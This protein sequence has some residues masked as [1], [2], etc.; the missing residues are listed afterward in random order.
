M[1]PVAFICLT[2]SHL[3]AGSG[4]VWLQPEQNVC[5]QIRRERTVRWR[6]RQKYGGAAGKH[7]NIRFMSQLLHHCRQWKRTFLKLNT[8]CCHVTHR[9]R[10]SGDWTCDLVVA[11]L[12]IYQLETQQQTNLNNIDFYLNTHFI[13]FLLLYLSISNQGRI[14]QG[15]SAAADPSWIS[16]NQLPA[17]NS[18]GKEWWYSF[19]VFSAKNIHITHFCWFPQFLFSRLESHIYH[20]CK[21][22]QGPPA[23]WPH[24]CVNTN[25]VCK[26]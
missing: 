25:N 16:D 5:G 1:Q 4:T 24:V 6:W 21:K 3:L 17:M 23:T 15:F 22:K 14:N 18:L 7:K 2:I 13:I 10:H 19:D 12:S 20:R 9:R 8:L 26:C 11:G